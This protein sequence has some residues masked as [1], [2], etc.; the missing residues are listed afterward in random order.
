MKKILIVTANYYKDITASLLKSANN[1]LN[2]FSTKI[3]K[4]PGV[5]EVPVV[6]SQNIK[7]YDGFIALGCVIK[8]ETPHFD[9][10]SNAATQAIMNLSVDSKKPIGNGIITCL[11]MKQAKARSK[12]GKEA[13]KAVISILEQ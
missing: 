5:F 6:I 9:F 11:N 10:I 12:K 2:K 13:A 7:K 4:V 1:N 3:I 8:G